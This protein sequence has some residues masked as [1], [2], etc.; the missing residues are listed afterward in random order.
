VFADEAFS[1]DN[2]M[3]ESALKALITEATIMVELKGVDVTEMRN[4]IHLIMASNEDWVVPVRLDD[5]RF[6]IVDVADDHRRDHPYFKAME[7]QMDNGG[8]EALLH[9]LLSYDLSKFDVRTPPKTAELQRQQQQSLTNVEAFWFQRLY[10]GRLMPGHGTWK[11]FTLKNEM[12][13]AFGAETTTKK[14]AHGT[15]THLGMFFQRLVPGFKSERK[16]GQTTEWVDSRGTVRREENPWLWVFADLDKC[17]AR[18]DAE[19][20]KQKWPEMIEMVDVAVDS[21]E[22]F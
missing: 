15:K 7:D 12:V 18:W 21:Q 9:Y 20:G 1:T 8:R 6:F 16:R 19:F 17:R 11:G 5:R 22:P 14:S 10:E 3:H 2:K 4:C 13:D